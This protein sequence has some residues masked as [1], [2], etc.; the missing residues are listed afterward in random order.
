ME[1]VCTPKEEGGLG[2]RRMK[3]VVLMF[4]MKMIWWL[5]DS[6]DSFWGCLGE[7]LPDLK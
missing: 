2:V 6:S 1:E 7:N 3:D 5:F 4:S